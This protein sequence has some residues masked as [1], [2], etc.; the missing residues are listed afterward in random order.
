MANFSYNTL[1]HPDRVV[2]PHEDY[3]ELGEENEGGQE[4]GDILLFQGNRVVFRDLAFAFWPNLAL[5]AD[6]LTALAIT[7]LERTPLCGE[8]PVLSAPAGTRLFIPCARG[9]FHSWPSV[10]PVPPGS[11]RAGCRSAREP[12]REVKLRAR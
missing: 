4:K 12:D 8:C 9:V 1:G 2:V 10:S 7:S 3:L 11:L 5:Q 6:R